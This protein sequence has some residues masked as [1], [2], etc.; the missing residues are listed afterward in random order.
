MIG[1]P[2]T[3]TA[4]SAHWGF[5]DCHDQLGNP[6]TVTEQGTLPLDAKD[7]TAGVTT[8]QGFPFNLNLAE[9]TSGGC[10]EQISG[11]LGPEYAAGTFTIS[12]S[13]I[14]SDELVAFDKTGGCLPAIPNT[15][16]Y[17]AGGKP[18][19]PNGGSSAFFT[20]LQYS[21]APSFDISSP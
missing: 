16:A 13:I 14:V 12:P 7:E 9:Q 8:F 5:T 19:N 15:E 2:L 6:W 11:T 3:H 10:T 17:L 18:G 1:P 21:F 20:P 4:S